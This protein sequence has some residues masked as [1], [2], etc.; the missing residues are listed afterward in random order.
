MT[1]ALAIFQW[2]SEQQK[3]T[4]NDVAQHFNAVVFVFFV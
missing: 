2:N 1:E 4:E 3:K